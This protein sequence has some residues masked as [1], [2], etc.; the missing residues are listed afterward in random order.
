M[1]PKPA[2]V[3]ESWVA[4]HEPGPGIEEVIRSGGIIP[5]IK[6]H[7]EQFG[8]G[9]KEAKDAVDAVRGKARQP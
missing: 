5:A 7:R 1:T 6:R 9:L 2:P 4:P 3:T 8:S